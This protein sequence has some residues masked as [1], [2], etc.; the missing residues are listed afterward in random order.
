MKL[1]GSLQR[2]NAI[3]WKEWIQIKRDARSLILSLFAPV[4]LLMLF[5][6]ALTVD[7]R[8]VKTAIYDQ[9]MSHESRM[10]LEV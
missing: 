2:I 3:S 8:H 10:L 7:V 1:A 6:Y 4:F 9:D 5:G